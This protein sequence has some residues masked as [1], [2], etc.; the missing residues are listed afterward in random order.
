MNTVCV[1]T[2][3]N[4]ESYVTYL[5]Y[6]NIAI[7]LRTIIHCHS[8]TYASSDMHIVDILTTAGT[9]YRL[10]KYLN[11]LYRIAGDHGVHEQGGGGYKIQG[12]H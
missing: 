5:I 8:S 11:I 4:V 2:K 12:E 1:F 6:R 3:N 9:G 10:T 7:P